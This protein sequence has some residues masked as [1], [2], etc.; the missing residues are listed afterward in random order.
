M[1]ALHARVISQSDRASLVFVADPEGGARDQLARRHGVV[2]LAEPALDSI[3]ALVIASPTDSHTD[4]CLKAIDAGV[5]FLVEKPLSRRPDEV[6]AVARGALKA[7]VPFTVGFVERFNP[8]IR[9]MRDAIEDP[10]YFSAIR[11]SPYVERIRSGVASD[12]LIH[13]IDLAVRSLDGVPHTVGASYTHVHPSSAP[14]AEDVAEVHLRFA[15]GIKLA[16]LSASRIAQRK[17]RSITLASL[18]RSA[19]LDLIRFD[20]T[21]YRHV[22]NAPLHDDRPGYRQETIMEIPELAGREEPL[23]AQFD[24]FLALARG[25]RDPVAEADSVILPHRVLAAAD[26]AAR[27]GHPQAVPA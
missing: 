17:I 5:P 1:G 16:S 14:G 18:E 8:A 6:D 21:I 22:L 7:G 27:S 24:H 4:W 15:G 26:E 10:I 11:H 25:D 2:G 12:L 13:D 9:T 3:D 23:V 19:E 20:I